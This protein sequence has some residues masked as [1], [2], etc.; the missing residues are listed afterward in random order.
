MVLA[1][2]WHNNAVL[3]DSMSQEVNFLA[4]SPIDFVDVYSQAI[5]RRFLTPFAGQIS[6]R[7]A[8]LVQVHNSKVVTKVQKAAVWTLVA[9]NMLFAFFGLALTLWAVGIGGQKYKARDVYQVYTR[10]GVMG[11]SAQL[12]EKDHSARQVEDEQELF[13]TRY[14]EKGRSV[15]R[16][17]IERTATGG[18]IFTV[19]E[20]GEK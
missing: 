11:L 10:L 18:S 4:T 2:M 1:E 12:F 3:F 19:S 8:L 6:P 7:P 20:K 15:K 13:E 5:S 9:A 14:E 17:G 16:V